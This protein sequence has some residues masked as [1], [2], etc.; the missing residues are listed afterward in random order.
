[1]TLVDTCV[2]SLFLRRRN[3]IEHPALDILERLLND[4]Q[5]AVA[6]LVYQE[7]LS[8]LKSRKQFEL[9]DDILSGFDIILADRDDQRMA[10][11]FH[12]LCRSKGVQRSSFDLLLCAMAHRRNFSILTTDRDFEHYARCIPVSLEPFNP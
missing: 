3:Q 11:E 1:M 6:G 9:L 7:L 10:A 4:D 12:S 5:A 2:W 8:G